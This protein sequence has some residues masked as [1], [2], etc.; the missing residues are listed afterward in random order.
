[1]RNGDDD[2]DLHQYDD[3]P[4]SCD[5]ARF[6]GPDLGFAPACQDLYDRN[7]IFDYYL[8]MEDDCILIDKDWDAHLIELYESTF[9]HK[10]GLIQLM[11]TSNEIRCEMVSRQWIETLGYFMKPELRE[12]AVAGLWTI[13]EGMGLNV[14]ADKARVTHKGAWRGGYSNGRT[15][16]MSPEALQRYQENEVRL[17]NWVA[18]PAG[19]DTDVKKI[20]EAIEEW[21]RSQ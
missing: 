7:Q 20:Q 3:V 17:A 8:T 12:H 10:H 5:L 6:I 14:F 15:E 1:M 2:P 21:R 4:S 18:D 13:G 16:W 11:D 19:F 9:P